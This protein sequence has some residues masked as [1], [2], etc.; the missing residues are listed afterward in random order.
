MS[1]PKSADYGVSDEALRL[2]RNRRRLAALDAEVEQIAAQWRQARDE[3]GDM[4]PAWIQESALKGRIQAAADQRLAS[5][6][7]A[8]IVAHIAQEVAKARRVFAQLSAL[9]RFHGSLAAA[10]ATQPAQ[11]TQQ[12]EDTLR[13]HAE[14]VSDLLD[15]LASQ[16]SNDEREALARRGEEAIGALPGRRKALLLQLRQD[17]QRA[18]AAASKRLGMVRK[19]EQWREEIAGFDGPQVEELD[20]LLRRVAEGQTALAPD[21]AQRVKDV[22]ASANKALEREYASKVIVEE[23]QQMGYEVEVGFETA[24][25]AMLLRKPGMPDD[26]HVELRGETGESRLHARV[27]READGDRAEASQSS[28]RKQTDTEAEQ[29]WCGDFASALAA[30]ERHGVQARL[31]SRLRAGE[32]P[33]QSIAPLADKRQTQRRRRR[34]QVQ[35]KARSRG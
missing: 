9:L 16:V 3:H 25:G 26:Y 35:P 22:V 15:T 4:V 8:K 24:S 10:S 32:Q 2:E 5:D 11:Q 17:I 33:V 30:A 6:E 12:E 1:G 19:A 31:T 13:R 14:Q 21:M 29:S 27:V 34:R 18:N 20:Q 28:D 7:L 23:L